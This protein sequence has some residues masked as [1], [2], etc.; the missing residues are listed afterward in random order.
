MAYFAY[1]AVENNFII[2]ISSD[3]RS[4]HALPANQTVIR[5]G[6]KEAG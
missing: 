5:Y 1:S 2:Y 4:Y 6:R 3:M